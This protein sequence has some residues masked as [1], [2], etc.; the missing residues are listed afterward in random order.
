MIFGWDRKGPIQKPS[1]HRFSM[2][3]FFQT[4]YK[5][6][7]IFLRCPDFKTQNWSWRLR[8]S[9]MVIF[10]WVPFGPIL[11]LLSSWS[12]THYQGQVPNNET[13]YLI[14]TAARNKFC[15]VLNLGVCTYC[16][17]TLSPDLRCPSEAA[18]GTRRTP[19]TLYSPRGAFESLPFLIFY[20]FA[21]IRNFIRIIKIHQYL[22]PWSQSTDILN[23]FP[24]HYLTC[25]NSAENF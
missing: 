3:F 23:M 13:P 1:K 6:F 8:K 7:G 22:Y 19:R 11:G 18:S 24:L 25:S 9:E 14:L 15:I 4:P 5:S 20:K 21:R 12:S 2:V 10:G 17:C 16:V